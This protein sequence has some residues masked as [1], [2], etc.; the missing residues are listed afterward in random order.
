[1]GEDS[2]AFGLG[3][4]FE[5][6]PLKD[7]RVEE[8]PDQALVAVRTSERPT[9]D[10]AAPAVTALVTELLI[11]AGLETADHS[12]KVALHGSDGETVEFY[13]DLA[14]AVHIGRDWETVD[15][16]CPDPSVSRRH[17]R[18][19]VRESGEPVV[20]DL[21]SSNGTWIERRGQRIA[22]PPGRAL[23]LEN[24]DR[25]GTSDDV[26]IARVEIRETL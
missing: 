13:G 25:L 6:E 18:V 5:P 19:R 21:A 26:V 20:E 3:L 14:A 15:L 8:G 4:H 11:A 7:R 2:S 24:E 10:S 23:A 12:L 9:P 16:V 1:M 17:A 22:V